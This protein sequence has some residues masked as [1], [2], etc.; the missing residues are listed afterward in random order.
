MALSEA[1]GNQISC[2]SKDFVSWREVGVG[3]Q[4]TF[5]MNSS[6]TID[7]NDTT[8][9]TDPTI[10]AL[11]FEYNQDIFFLPVEVAIALPELKAYSAFGCS[12]KKIAKVHFE[13]LKMLKFLCLFGNLIKTIESDTF[14]DLTSLIELDL[15]K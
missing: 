12:I 6:T 5:S 3:I 2:E 7:T 14:E 1:K 9:L 8:I 11:D 13:G 15:S 4:Y 10:T